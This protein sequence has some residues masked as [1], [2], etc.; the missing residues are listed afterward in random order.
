VPNQS[1]LL[2]FVCFKKVTR[3][4]GIKLEKGDTAFI[5]LINM[6]HFILKMFEI[7]NFELIF[8]NLVGSQEFVAAIA[9]KFSFSNL[10]SSDTPLS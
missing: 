1:F 2:I 6:L 3:L 8:D 7:R 10:D 5:A 9:R 4:E